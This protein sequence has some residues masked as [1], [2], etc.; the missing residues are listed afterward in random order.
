M[1]TKNNWANETDP[2]A[3]NLLTSHKDDSVVQDYLDNSGNQLLLGR[4]DYRMMHTVTYY[5]EAH[6]VEHKIRRHLE[7]SSIDQYAQE[8]WG[9]FHN[10]EAYYFMHKMCLI[11][12]DLYRNGQLAP[13]QMQA[14]WEHGRECIGFRPHPGSDREVFISVMARLGLLPEAVPVQFEI[15][16]WMQDYPINPAFHRVRPLLQQVTTREQMREYYLNWDLTQF[17]NVHWDRQYILDGG[18]G[19]MRNFMK[20]MNTIEGDISGQHLEL[21]ALTFR[22]ELRDTLERFLDEYREFDDRIEF[23]AW[24]MWHH[25]NLLECDASRLW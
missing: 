16:P 22:I 20:N 23:G 8:R 15:Y 25:K 1:N 4:L 2:K 19:F 12:G 18:P 21:K 24:T 11:S 5:T 13:L 10:H 6:S 14:A 3:I 7:S 9:H 17:Y